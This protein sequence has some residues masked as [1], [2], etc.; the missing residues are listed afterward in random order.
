MESSNVRDGERLLGFF[1]RVIGEKRRQDFDGYDNARRSCSNVPTYKT[2]QWPAATAEDDWGM[3]SK[4]D[5]V[6]GQMGTAE[7][8]TGW[9]TESCPSRQENAVEFCSVPGTKSPRK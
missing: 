7:N 8:R 3:Q 9:V 6:V 2:T 1:W 5:L 4:V